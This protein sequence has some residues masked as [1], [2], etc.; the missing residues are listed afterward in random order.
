M[1]LMEC[2]DNNQKGWKYGKDGF[3]YTGKDAKEKATRQGQAIELQ[4][5]KD[6]EKD[7]KWRIEK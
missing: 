3:C 7:K 5:L 2:I 4:K 1:P 6:S